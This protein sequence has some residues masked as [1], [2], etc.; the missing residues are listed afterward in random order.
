MTG[1]WEKLREIAVAL[2]STAGDRFDLFSG[3]LA[4][5]QASRRATAAQIL[6]ELD[7]LER[8]AAAQPVPIP[9][10]EAVVEYLQVLWPQLEEKGDE[11]SLY[12]MEWAKGAL[13]SCGVSLESPRSMERL[14]EL[15][16]LHGGGKEKG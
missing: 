2:N 11:K 15:R 3:P 16:S 7:R 9:S 5:M 12:A 13:T 1:K 10:A 4:D 6:D 14:R 8:E